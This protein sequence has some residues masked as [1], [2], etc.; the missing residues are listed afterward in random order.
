MAIA[1]DG[2]RYSYHALSNLAAINLDDGTKKALSKIENGDVEQLLKYLGES[3]DWLRIIKPDSSGVEDFS[4]SEHCVRRSLKGALIENQTENTK[5]FECKKQLNA[6]NMSPFKNIYTTN[7]DLT[8]YWVLQE[9]IGYR[10]ERKLLEHLDEF[11][12]K[13][14]IKEA[15]NPRFRFLHGALHIFTSGKSGAKKVRRSRGGQSLLPQIKEMWKNNEEPVL[16]MGGLAQQKQELIAGND[17]LKHCY[18]CL[19]QESG[20]M[21]VF[22]LSMGE[23]DSHLLEALCDSKLSLVW[24]P[25]YDA[26]DRVRAKVWFKRLRDTGKDVRFYN[27]RNMNWWTSKLWDEAGLTD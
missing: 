13:F 18:N 3:K 21:L 8:S 25:I 5:E 19:C 26:S 24:L 11:S 17:Y 9:L 4:N 20:T 7:Y 10:K 6:E 15:L 16:V 27:A 1:L 12:P 23:S 2:D 22:G 14:S